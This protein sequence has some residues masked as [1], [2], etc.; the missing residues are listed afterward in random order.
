MNQTIRSLLHNTNHDELVAILH[1]Y[2][3]NEF[4]EKIQDEINAI[5]A[6]FFNE[7]KLHDYADYNDRN[8]LAQQ[9]YKTMFLTRI[10]TVNDE[11]AEKIIELYIY[12]K[13]K[14]QTR[15]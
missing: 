9:I 5:T 8:K 1:F 2:P 3:I 6:K 4:I 10:A 7:N 13:P 14:Y 15:K 12:N 11:E